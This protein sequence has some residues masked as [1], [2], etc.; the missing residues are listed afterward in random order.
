MS[1]IAGF[2]RR[3]SRK[4]KEKDQKSDEEGEIQISSPTNFQRGIHVAPGSGVLLA[5]CLRSVIVSL[6]TVMQG[7]LSGLPAE[8][9]ADATQYFRVD[10][11]AAA[12]AADLPAALKPTPK[13]ALPPI[14][15]TFWCHECL[16]FLFWCNSRESGFE[17]GQLRQRR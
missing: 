15:S 8:W 5:N 14:P 4:E 16:L 10:P 11:T 12:A 6:I 7:Q 13:S 17:E 3:I 1:A 9:A 2:L